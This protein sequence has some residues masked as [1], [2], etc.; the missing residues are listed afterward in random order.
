MLF[1]FVVNSRNKVVM[2]R[3]W[4]RGWRTPMVRRACPLRHCSLYP[5]FGL[6]ALLISDLGGTWKMNTSG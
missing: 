5:I 2:F 4:Y 3:V 6:E 1:V